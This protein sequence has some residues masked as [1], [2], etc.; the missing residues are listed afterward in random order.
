MTNLFQIRN[1]TS[2]AGLNLTWK[3]EC[4]A[5]T[6]DDWDCIAHV[7]VAMLPKFGRVLAVP[8]GGIPLAKSFEFYQQAS[9]ELTLVVDDVWTTG[10]SMLA[11]VKELN[12]KD[13][14]WVGFVGFARGALFPKV[15]AFCKLPGVP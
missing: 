2:A 3:I 12:L 8:S 5:L 1:F 4:D 7:G 11:L 9:S 13:H 6:E 15:H 10:K 14:E